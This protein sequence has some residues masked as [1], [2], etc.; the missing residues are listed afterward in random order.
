[1]SGQS[2]CANGFA[3][4]GRLLKKP[5]FNGA[6]V[7]L[8]SKDRESGRWICRTADGKEIKVQEIN[9]HPHKDM[10]TKE[11]VNLIQEEPKEPPQAPKKA[12]KESK[13]LNKASKFQSKSI[14]ELGPNLK[15]FVINLKRREDR[16][17]S[18]EE[19][20]TKLKLKDVEIVEAC[21]GKALSEQP[22]AEFRILRQS[23]SK[24]SSGASS[25]GKGPKAKDVK[26]VRQ[27]AAKQMT[28]TQRAEATKS[29]IA[30]KNGENQRA[31]KGFSGCAKKKF[32]TYFKLNGKDTCQPMTMAMH[33]V[34]SS[35]KTRRGHELWGAVG[36]NLSHQV[37]LQKILDDPTIDYALILE[38][39]CIL[40]LK[41]G[42]E[43]VRT[44]NKEMRMISERF[45]QWQLIYLGGAICTSHKKAERDSW[46]I[47]KHVMRAKAVYLT[48]AFV[49]RRNMV[50]QILKKLKE[51]F[52]ADAAYVSWTRSKW[53]KGEQ[54][55]C[56]LFQ[57]H[58]LKQPGN[59]NRWKDSD[60]FAEGVHF[61]KAL[62]E[63]LEEQGEESSRYSFKKA[64]ELRTRVKRQD[65][66]RK[67]DV[68]D[69]QDVYH[70]GR[71]MDD[72]RRMKDDMEEREERSHAKKIKEREE[73]K[74]R[75]EERKKK[76][77]AA[78]KEEE[79]PK[80]KFAEKDEETG[81]QEASD[82]TSKKREKAEKTRASSSGTKQREKKTA[83]A[84]E[85][86][87]RAKPKPR[88]AW[89]GKEASPAETEELN[90]GATPAAFDGGETPAAFEGGKTPVLVLEVDSD[91][92]QEVEDCREKEVAK[93]ETSKQMPKVN[94]KVLKLLKTQQEEPLFLKAIQNAG[95]QEMDM[96]KLFSQSN[97]PIKEFQ[98]QMKILVE[99]A[100]FTQSLHRTALVAAVSAAV[101]GGMIE[102]LRTTVDDLQLTACEVY[103]SKDKIIDCFMCVLDFLRVPADDLKRL[104]A[105]MQ[106]DEL[107]NETA[108]E[109]KDYLGKGPKAPSGIV[110]E[111]NMGLFS[112]LLKKF[113]AATSLLHV[114]ESFQQQQLSVI[115]EGRQEQKPA[116]SSQAVPAPASLVSS[117]T[118]AP[119]TPRLSGE[120]PK[121]GGSKRKETAPDP[122]ASKER[123][124]GRMSVP[125]L[126]Q[127][128][129]ELKVSPSLVM[130]CLER[131]DLMEVLNVNR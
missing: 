21:D 13:S 127:K 72:K 125:E 87:A 100:R 65:I 14:P 78:T 117:G 50:A 92:P 31:P 96:Q 105:A 123:K 2:L 53:A 76:E 75:V 64:C 121:P 29:A 48:H 49:V 58:L 33:R 43:V 46:K 25:K 112:T 126:R 18:I 56:F 60:I 1:M 110:L 22:N 82:K 51:G 3:V 95:L 27:I 62:E 17:A 36:C 5:E 34:S 52:A 118:G 88:K 57:P 61:K 93:Q 63:A 116:T 130:T 45:P 106:M 71:A 113:K 102:R 122:G 70:M 109:L 84:E 19:L 37:V 124:K 111:A 114:C 12:S 9:L 47:D 24:A 8:V 73:T 83:D 101:Q 79:V 85:Q 119:G 90:G 77:A 40:G 120:P 115:E 35:T 68:N 91:S 6:K 129:N 11:N 103:R 59:E 97:D 94:R 128:A 20:C 30:A 107:S 80:K 67:G 54:S 69:R 66:G 32:M 7:T 16:R 89:S 98:E 44:F 39:D 99:G 23:S 108:A 55:C 42:E 104:E 38:D 26:K 41:S 15:T 4:I 131:N 86:P 74:A 81:K 10:E 28:R